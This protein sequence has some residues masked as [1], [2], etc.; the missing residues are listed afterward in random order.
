E[1]YPDGISAWYIQVNDVIGNHWGN[2]MAPTPEATRHWTFDNISPTS[3]IFFQ[4][5][6]DESKNITTNNRWF[7]SFD[8]IDLKIDT[9]DQAADTINYQVLSGDVACPAQNDS[10]YTATGHNT[11]LASIINAKTDGAYSMC[12]YASDLA[13]NTEASTYKELLRKDNTNPSFTIDSVSGNVLGGVYYNQT[14]ITA[15]ITVSDSDSGYSH[16]RYDLYNADSNHACTTSIGSNQDSISS[17]VNPAIRTLSKTGLSDG[18]YCFRVW[19]YDNVQNKVWTDTSGFNG[20]IK[21]TIDSTLPTNPG[22]PTTTPNPTNSLIQNW[23][24]IDS[25]DLNGISQYL[26][27]IP[28]YSSGIVLGTSLTT[29]LGEGIW[30]LFIKAQDNAGNQSSEVSSSVQV[31]TTAPDEPTATL[32]ANGANVPTNGYTNSNTFTF[33]LSSAE[34]TRYQLKYW[35]GISGSSF[36]VATP[37]N[38]TDLGGYS[39]S[40]GVYNDNFTQ[41]EG[42]HYFSFSACD[43]AGNCSAYSTTP[44]IVTYDKTAPAKPTITTPTA[45]Q[46]FKTTPILNKWGIVTDPSGI[47]QYTVEYIYDDGHLFSGAPYRYTTTNSRSHSPSM[48]EQGGVTIRVRAEDNIGNIGE[49]SDPVHYVYDATA[50]AFNS[51]TSFSGWYKTNQTSIFTYSDSFGVVSGAP[52]TCDITTEGTNQTC[53]VTPNVCDAAGNCNTTLVT[54]N[55]VDIDKTDP[56]V[57]WVTP[58]NSDYVK[59]NIALEINASDATSGV[60]SVDFKFKLEGGSGYDPISTDTSDPYQSSWDSIGVSD[61]EYILRT[62]TKDNAGNGVGSNI[63]VFVDNTNPTGTWINPID[64]QTVSGSVSLNFSADDNLSE[65]ASVVYWYSSD[66]VIFTSIGSDT[67]DTTTLP[68]GDYT[69]RA[70]VTDNAGNSANFDENVGVAAVIS[71]ENGASS[72]YGTATITWTTDR[73]TKSRVVYDTTSHSVLGDA[74]NYGYAYSTGTFDS[75]PKTTSHSVTITSLSDGTIYYYRT[76]SEGSPTAI[77][78]Q[79]SYRTLSIAGAPSPSGGEISGQVAG[80]STIASNYQYNQASNSFSENQQLATNEEVLG[81]NTESEK[82]QTPEVKGA[83]TK[84]WKARNIALISFGSA[85]LILALLLLWRKNKQSLASYAG[86]K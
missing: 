17:F 33:N 39:S 54:S 44:F 73:P 50:P 60:Q 1:I 41:G 16:A 78:D 8:N 6:L 42:T 2:M 77:G 82:T 51:K 57:S 56:T 66:G 12:Y 14:D 86:K 48:S 61:G 9:G 38:P 52:V 76:I 68:L 69:L 67:W 71:A 4:A 43:I 47:K 31:D 81:E 23:A 59:G 84:D 30:S 75:D 21:F 28:S 37:W 18:N 29:S 32:T 74:P 62:Y 34:A 3:S 85:L 64:E 45:E 65:V 49:W 22:A 79:K 72:T 53:S 27:R 58:N 19:A 20:W 15:Q 83:E 26:W 7:E 80:I 10:N 24:W 63:N 13:G 11:N 36:K 46:Y 70:V 35:N 5:D 55:G 25:T 40:L